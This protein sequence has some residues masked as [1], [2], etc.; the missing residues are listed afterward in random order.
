MVDTNHTMESGM[1]E[2]TSAL[3]A[4]LSGNPAPVPA[5]PSPEP[6]PLAPEPAPEPVPAPLA[7]EPPPVEPGGEPPTP[8]APVPSAPEPPVPG[9]ATLDL[10]DPAAR[11]FLE[12][13]GGDPNKALASALGYNNRLAA[14]YRENPERFQAGGD[15]DPNREIEFDEPVLFEDP[16]PDAPSLDYEVDPGAIQAAV[17]AAVHQDANSTSLITTFMQNRQ[18]LEGL[19]TQA[20]QHTSEIQYLERRLQDPEIVD[21]DLRR[22]DI[23]NQIERLQ[24]KLDRVETQGDRLMSAN[25]RLNGQFISRRDQIAAH[26]EGEMT[27][28]A[29]E[30]TLT[31]YE[32]SV[33]QQEYQKALVEWP[34][35]LERCIRENN[36]P[37]EQV[38]DFKA[39]AQR[40]FKAEM[41]DPNAVI[42]D[43]YAF[44]SPVAKDMVA[45]LDR[46]HRVR[47]GQYATAAGQRA[48]TP[49]PRTGGATP[50]PPTAQ[51]GDLDS[52]MDETRHIWKQATRG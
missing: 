23:E 49:S 21:D 10:S 33:E 43:M 6:Q 7:A 44:L 13:H 11:R 25:E 40:A 5:A 50:G 24:T 15:L 4:A 12:M 8:P 19:Q 32:H 20:N 37:P 29:E 38:E 34:S 36:I 17:N 47:A 26:I 16:P 9:A 3:G 35:A 51:D 18:Q 42:D 30:E 1:S 39:D 2:A 41:S 27:Q 31:A 48:A 28:Q 14:A 45:R 22:P 46:Y 52:I